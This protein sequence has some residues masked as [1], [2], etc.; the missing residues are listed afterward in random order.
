MQI[1]YRRAAGC[2]RRLIV[3]WKN[4][5]RTGAQR[6]VVLDGTRTRSDPT[7]VNACSAADC[8]VVR[9]DTA[10]VMRHRGPG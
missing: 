10:K 6:C 4:G 3:D 5:L 1:G 9:A 8:K 2:P 7:G